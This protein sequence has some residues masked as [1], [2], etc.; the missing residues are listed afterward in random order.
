MSKFK[1][2]IVD[3]I[4]DQ[5]DAVQT[6]LVR[7]GSSSKDKQHRKEK[8]ETLFDIARFQIGGEA[9]DHLK[10][11]QPHLAM[12]DIRFTALEQVPE[13]VKEH[14]YD[15]AQEATATRGVDILVALREKYPSTFLIAYTGG[16]IDE[17]VYGPLSYKGIMGAKFF[18]PLFK[19]DEASGHLTDKS[20]EVLTQMAEQ[21]YNDL[22]IK[23][24]KEA[25]EKSDK[26]E[27]ALL[28][29]E[30]KVD[31]TDCPLWHL[32]AHLAVLDSDGKL[33]YPNLQASI[34]RILQEPEKEQEVNH[35]PASPPDFSP[36]GRWKEAWM[37]QA[38]IDFRASDGYE[39]EN[40]RINID[41]ANWILNI[42]QANHNNQILGKVNIT[43]QKFQ[44]G[45]PGPTDIF[46]NA[47]LFRRV[48]MGCSQ[49]LETPGVTQIFKV[50]S[51]ISAQQHP[52]SMAFTTIF[53]FANIGTSGYDNERRVMSVILGL[54]LQRGYSR[55]LQRLDI[56]KGNCLTE[57]VAFL[58][59]FL[60]KIAK[61]FMPNNGGP[62]K[63]N[64]FEPFV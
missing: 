35:I 4:E 26:S 21:R 19:K 27:A 13:L 5:L 29:L 15:L 44:Y 2:M 50:Y 28:N 57:E 48:L 61:R 46:H 25:F 7:G 18:L 37:H 49:L 43:I 8:A 54:S 23:L 34:E 32:M 51:Y 52:N 12:V 63:A 14:G 47:L 30:V 40:A 60:P 1:I 38:I 64:P 55:K 22:D 41:A 17:D 6:T 53:R 56:N 16:G 62:L 20:H 42:I 9:I 58:E 33:T 10:G 24:L 11:W 36:N 31:G 45:T 3:D 59:E 39:K